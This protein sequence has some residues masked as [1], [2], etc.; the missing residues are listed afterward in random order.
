MPAGLPDPDAA[1][2][3]AQGGQAPEE[4][5]ARLSPTTIITLEGLKGEVIEDGWGNKYEGRFFFTVPTNG[6]Q[7]EIGK[8]KSLYLPGGA[9]ADINAATIV[10][11][12]CY[13]TSTITFDKQRPKPSWWEPLEAYSMEPYT[14]LYG[15]CLDYEARFHGRG[16]DR[17]GDADGVPGEDGPSGADTVRV[18]SEVPPPPKRSETLTGDGS[19]GS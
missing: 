19:G 7:I 3:K 11:V 5:R 12:V 6:K 9:P 18:G 14:A 2:A 13:L 15:R 1:L 4:K 8:M 16:E 10:D 17:G